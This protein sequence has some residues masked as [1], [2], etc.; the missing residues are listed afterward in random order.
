MPAS[1]P[2][3]PRRARARHAGLLEQRTRSR[4]QNSKLA[5]RQ[6][7]ECLDALAGNLH[8]RFGFA[9]SLARRVQR[10]RRSGHERLE[11]RQPPLG[12]CDAVSGDD[13]ESRRKATR[14]R[15]HERRVGRPRE[16]AQLQAST[17]RRKRVDD[18]IEGGETLESVQQC[19]ECHY[20]ARRL[21]APIAI[22]SM[23]SMRSAAMSAASMSE[24]RA[25]AR[26]AMLD[27]APPSGAAS[28]RSDRIRSRS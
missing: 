10:E 6:S 20:A 26:K 19:V 13:E 22:A 8:V 5:A 24:R 3:T 1:P 25:A 27:H 9:E 18:S 4:E 28:V 23:M 7:L 21:R 12:F 15:G 2:A 16:A 14:Q 11:I 17:R